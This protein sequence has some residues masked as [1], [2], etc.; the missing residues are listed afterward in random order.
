MEAINKL[1]QKLTPCTDYVPDFIVKGCSDLFVPILEPIF[2]ISLS[3][4]V[5]PSV[6]EESIF[7]PIHKAVPI[8]R[9]LGNIAPYPCYVFCK[10]IQDSDAHPY[11]FLF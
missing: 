6:W 4:G 1:K 5:S 7:V 10:G 2:N 3:W 9:R 11:F 8:L